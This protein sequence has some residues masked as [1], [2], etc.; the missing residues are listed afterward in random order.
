LLIKQLNITSPHWL[1]NN[2]HPA[3]AK[4]LMGISISHYF[5]AH[6]MLFQ[7]RISSILLGA[8]LVVGVY[9]LGRA[10]FGRTIALLAALSL[11]LSPW[12]VQF[13]Q[14]PHAR[15]IEMLMYKGALV[16]I[17]VIP[18]EE[19]YTSQASFLDLDPLPAYDPSREESLTFSGRRSGRWYS[20]SGKRVLHADVNGSYN[21]LRKVA[22]TALDGRGVGGAAVRPWRLAV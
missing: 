7:A 17:Q 15:F 4:L 19:S 21:I 1:Y 13:V 10:P 3:F 16:G 5:H 6:S 11:A 18:H 9:A 20:A 2:E 14:I 12:V 8:A 22:P